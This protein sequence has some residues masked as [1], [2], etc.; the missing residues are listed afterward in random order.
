M[1]FSKAAVRSNI[2]KTQV[3]SKLV[4]V[5]TWVRSKLVS[6]NRVTEMFSKA[7]VR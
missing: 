1:K 3:R 7:A 5:K 2:I 6:L 4:M